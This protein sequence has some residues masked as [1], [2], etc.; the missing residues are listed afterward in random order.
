MGQGANGWDGVDGSEMALAMLSVF[1]EFFSL[2]WPNV[3][4]ILSKNAQSFRIVYPLHYY[5]F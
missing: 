1:T 3:V 2:L 4:T 5:V